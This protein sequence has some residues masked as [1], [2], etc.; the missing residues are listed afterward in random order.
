MV[1]LIQWRLFRI[2]INLIY[3][4]M[5]YTL[6][7]VFSEVKVYEFFIIFITLYKIAQYDK[8]ILI[9]LLN[10]KIEFIN[11]NNIKSINKNFQ[12]IN[13]YMKCN[14]SLSKVNLN[15][16]LKFNEFN[17][18]RKSKYFLIFCCFI[19]RRSLYNYD[20]YIFIYF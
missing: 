12:C 2:L 6:D 5:K 10:L 16:N 1:P 4:I 7:L 8:I 15:S 11:L 14:I 17:F 20:V 19:V 18:L 3:E 13:L 9:S